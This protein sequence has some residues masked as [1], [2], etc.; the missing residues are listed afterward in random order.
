MNAEAVC[1]YLV[2]WLQSEVKKAGCKGVVLGIS[3][4][5]DSAVA[6]GI[7]QRAFPDR[8]LGL[9][10]PC[11]SSL[12]DMMDAEKVLAK[13]PMTFQVIELDDVF[14]LLATQY[15]SFVK[16]DGQLGQLLRAN[17]KPRLRMITM[18]YAAQ[19]MNYLVIGTTNK[20]ELLVGYTT[21][22]GDSGVDLQ[23]LADLSK[24]EIYELAHYL[25]VPQEIINKAPSGGLWAGQTDEGEMGL[26]YQQLD[27]YVSQGSGDEETI[28]KI[29]SMAKRNEHKRC[30]PPI[31]IVPEKYR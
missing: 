10:L 6:A 15:E 7:A 31:A 4:G 30:M 14:Q 16:R 11:E 26:T 25:G 23:L 12:E 20:S 8:C 21:K 1:N 27:E 28:A 24:A 9:V 13:F 3:G 18:Y 19:A 5:V 17:I 22:H 2:E 29:Q